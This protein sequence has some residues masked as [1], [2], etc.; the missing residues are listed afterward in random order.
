MGRVDVDVLELLPDPGKHAEEALQRAHLPEHLHLVEEVVERELA[1][2]DGLLGLGGLLLGVGLLRLLDE[3]LDVAHPQDPAREPVGMEDLQVVEGL[4]GGGQLDRLAGDLPDRQCR[5]APRVTV[6]LGEHDPVEPDLVEERPG[7][8][9]GLLADHRV[10]HE[11][12]LVAGAAAARDLADPSR[13]PHHL[14]VHVQ[15]AGGVDDH[16]VAA[17][18]T[19]LVQRLL[20]HGDGVA[21]LD[22]RVDVDVGGLGVDPQLLDGGG[23]LQVA[24]HQHRRAAP[25]RQQASQLARRGGLP[26]A[27]QA[28]EHDH[29][30]TVP[31]QPQRNGLAPQGPLQLVGDGLDDLLG[32]VERLGDLLADQRLP[33][34]GDEL[35]DD[36]VVDVRLEQR[37]A[38]LPERL[39]DG[40]LVEPPAAADA[41]QG[42]VQPFRERFEHGASPSRGAAGDRP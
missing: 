32:R 17:A 25:L 42:G 12:G 4:A 5:P 29:R 39:V 13:L 33:Q 6:E 11:Q 20:R 41:V 37:E 24:G 14:L 7:H 10:D 2:E 35:L 22:R 26:G 40:L 19:G 38:D 1:R 16:H 8:V 36:F 30:G 34:P 31:L 3:R 9:D 23:A 18:L 27:L 21:R 15:A 28:G